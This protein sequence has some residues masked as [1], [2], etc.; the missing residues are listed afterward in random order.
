[1]V[2]DLAEESCWNE[3][4]VDWLLEKE[5]LISCES[6]DVVEECLRR[7]RRREKHLERPTI[8]PMGQ[9]TEY[10]AKEQKKR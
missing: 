5:R 9:Y 10:G 3:C 8:Y 1:M 4:N 2:A 6:E 7:K